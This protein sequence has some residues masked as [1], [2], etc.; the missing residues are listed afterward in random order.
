MLIL[1][2]KYFF[3]FFIFFFKLTLANAE[4]V[5]KILVDGNERIANETIIIFSKTNIGDDLTINN[6]NDI[7]KNLYETDFFKD[8]SVNLENNI[9]KI[10]VIEN[11]LVESIEINGVKNKKLK[12]ALL[13]QLTIAEKKSYVEEKSIQET[14]KLSNFL[15]LSGYY[16]SKVDLKVKQNDNN[17]VNLNYNIALNKKAVVNKI[18]FSG[19][20]FLNLDCFLKLLSLKKINF[21][22]F[23]QKKNI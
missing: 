11:S 2:S 1:M 15:K 7:I 23:C 22:N 20:K 6:L 19:N 18:N 17:T 21:G 10:N 14:L 8:V 12:Q 9:L 4:L 13:D 16:F 3:I 5:K